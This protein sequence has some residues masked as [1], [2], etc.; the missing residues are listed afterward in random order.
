MRTSLSLFKYISKTFLMNLLFILLVLLSVAFLISIVDIMRKAYI[1]NF[2]LIQ[3]VK[4]NLVNLPIILDEIFPYTIFITTIFTIEK[5]RTSKELIAINSFGISYFGA[6]IPFI[7]N[8]LLLSII[9]TTL[10]QPVVANCNLIYYKMKA[11]N[12]ERRI[13]T[14][15]QNGIWLR[16]QL[17]SGNVIFLNANYFY[18]IGKYLADVKI[19]EYSPLTK[20]FTIYFADNAALI[21]KELILSDV[22][23]VKPDNLSISKQS[24]YKFATNISGDEIFEFLAPKMFSLWN[25]NSFVT[26]LEKSGF[27]ALEHKFYFYRMLFSPLYNIS[28]VFI[29]MAISLIGLSNKHL[30]ISVYFIAGFFIYFISNLAMKMAGSGNLEYYIPI[31]ILP[32]TMIFFALALIM[33]QEE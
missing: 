4:I 3:I 8:T 16:D 11:Q 2:T 14:F 15:S 25:I 24:N 13:I 30:K 10:I 32:F 27:S 18:E 17:P 20:N 19:Y 12:D 33:R 5:F 7:I 22:S 21:S 6:F 31:L 29:A 26:T 1:S 9:Y 28:I 23:I